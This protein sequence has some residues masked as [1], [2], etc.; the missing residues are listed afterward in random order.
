MEMNT[1]NEEMEIDV[2][3]L[4]LELI[5]QWK[6]IIISMV[7]VAS[8][9]FTVT[10]FMITPTY[11]STSQ[12]YVL[13]KS[14][15]IT[16]LADLQTGTNLTQDYMVVVT[17]RPVIDKV[18]ENV[19]LEG[20]YEEVLKNIKVS[21]PSD[22]RILEI[23]VKDKDSNRAKKIADEVANVAAAY[24]SEKMDQDPP[25]II[26]LGYADGDPVSPNVLKNTVLGAA[27]GLFLAMFMVVLSYLLNDTIMTPDDME[28]KIGLNV[29]ASLPLD[30]FEDDGEKKGKKKQ[31][32]S[33]K[34]RV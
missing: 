5:S 19:G 14:T 16:S 25:N 22:S 20:T 1:K 21:N 10:K 32:S 8:I 2:K 30:E 7:L 12:L 15:S 11:E 34:K 6:L 3:E 17:G 13:S 27:A 29:L 26:Q 9:V 23:T 18:I 4:I 24:I 31:S 28:K 33:K